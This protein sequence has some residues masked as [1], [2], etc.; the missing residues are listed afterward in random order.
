MTHS[1]GSGQSIKV[2]S[3]RIVMPVLNEGATLALR[4]RALAPLRARGAELVVVDGGSTDDTWAIAAAL[5]DQVLSAPSGRASQMNAGARGAAADALLFLHADTAL[6]QDADLLIA[7]AMNAGNLWGRFDVRIEGKHPMLPV[8]AWL[9][10]QRSRWTGIATGDQGVFVSRA[11]FESL[12][13]FADVPLMEDIELSSRL[14]NQGAPA[15]LVASVITSGRRWETRGVWR[16]VAQM[17]WLR[18]AY[19]FGVSPAALATRYGYAP[20]P[21]AAGAALAIMARAPIAGQAKTRLMPLL[22]AHGAARAQRHFTRRTL[23]LAAAADLGDVTLW[24]APDAGQRFFRALYRVTGVALKSQSEGDLGV[25]MRQVFEHHFAQDLHCHTTTDQPLLLMGTDCPVLAPGHLQD[26]ARALQR[27]DVVIV[28][29][30]DGGYVLIGMRRPVLQV[31]E[32]IDWSTPQVLAQTR[33]QLTRVGASWVELPVLW[34][35]DEPADWL[36]LQQ[37]TR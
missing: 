2:P 29:A 24:C 31:F 35:V 16:T 8:I 32:G 1:P 5:A 11:T 9:M 21:D 25:R 19:F 12:G 18:A 17:W 4:I 22:G 20:R 14:K 28:P 37:L 26:A 13:G 34:D 15:C 36:R 3:L 30:E 27:C 6:P 10:N 33:S 23:Q 7:G